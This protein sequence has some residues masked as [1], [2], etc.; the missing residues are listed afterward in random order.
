MKR[1]FIAVLVVALLG[2]CNQANKEH[3][4]AEAI[5]TQDTLAEYIPIDATTDTVDMHQA[6]NSLDVIGI[7]KGTLPCADCEG[8]R[9][10]IELKADSTYSF[11]SSYLGKGDGQMNESTGT[12]VWLDGSRIELQGV[13]GG[14][15]KYFVGENTLTALDMDGNKVTGTLAEHYVLKK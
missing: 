6:Q 2:S 4:Q 11:K 15:Q 12:Y 13:D 14:P 9:T 3:V 8:I 7:Y 10:E 1:L 5:D